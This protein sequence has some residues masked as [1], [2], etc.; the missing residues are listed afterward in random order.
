MTVEIYSGTID[1]PTRVLTVPSLETIDPERILTVKNVTQ[2]RVVYTSSDRLTLSPEGSTVVLPYGSVHLGDSSS[3][4]IE[5][6]YAEKVYD[7]GGDG[8]RTVYQVNNE[9]VSFEVVQSE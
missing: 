1:V 6:R 9:L 5:V 2:G 7:T 3:D 4:E 8:P